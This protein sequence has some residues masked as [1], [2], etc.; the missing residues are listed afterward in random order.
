MHRTSRQEEG[1]PQVSLLFTVQSGNQ[2]LARDGRAPWRSLTPCCLVSFFPG[3]GDPLKS[4]PSCPCVLF[5]QR[6][7]E[8]GIG[9]IPG[10]I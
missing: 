7:K 6:A 10:S 5:Y 1:Q 8:E 2:G 3:V 9:T 4:L